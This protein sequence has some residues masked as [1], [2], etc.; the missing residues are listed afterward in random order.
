MATERRVMVAILLIVLI[1]VIAVDVSS[2]TGKLAQNGYAASKV[3]GGGAKKYGQLVAERQ[4]AEMR[5]LKEM[6][7]Y[8]YDN[9]EQWDC[10]Y[11]DEA[12]RSDYPCMYNKELQKYC[13]IPTLPSQI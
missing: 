3:Y 9:E 4:H 11:G 7:N 5:Y 1:S 13:C 10:S 6:Q 8:M 2:I 12:L